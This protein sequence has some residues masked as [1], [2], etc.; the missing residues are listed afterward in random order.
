MQISTRQCAIDQCRGGANRRKRIC[1][2]TF[3][4]TLDPCEKIKKLRKTIFS[5]FFVIFEHI[6]YKLLNSTHP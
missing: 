4:S 2:D 5:D 6:N 3:D 1:P